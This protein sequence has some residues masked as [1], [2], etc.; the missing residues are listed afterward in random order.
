[1]L[2]N[3]KTVVDHAVDT[4]VRQ[5]VAKAAQLYP[6]PILVPPSPRAAHL[7]RAADCN[8]AAPCVGG[9]VARAFHQPFAPV[10]LESPVISSSQ[11]IREAGGWEPFEIATIQGQEMCK[12]KHP[13]CEHPPTRP[14]P[15]GG[16]VSPPIA[17]RYPPLPPTSA[18]KPILSLKCFASR[19]I[20]VF[21]GHTAA[22]VHAHYVSEPDHLRLPRPP[23]RPLHTPLHRALGQRGDEARK[24]VR[25]L[26]DRVAPRLMAVH[27]ESPSHL[28]QLSLYL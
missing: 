3:F 15:P 14:L 19:V 22:T 6:V 18:T 16:E 7:S 12:A 26:L 21:I 28:F 8:T 11:Y 17:G 1:M 4:M 23:S 2:M 9:N 24:K 10:A 27:S 13:D 25:D 5:V 20:V